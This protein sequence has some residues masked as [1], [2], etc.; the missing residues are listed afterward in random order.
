VRFS[1]S[2][3]NADLSLQGHKKVT[4]NTHKFEK[5]IVYYTVDGTSRTP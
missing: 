3:V 5:Q 4:K 1:A 2:D